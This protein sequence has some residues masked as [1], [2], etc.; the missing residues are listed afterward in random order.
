VTV[1]AQQRELLA[2]LL[3]VTG[4][5]V[6][7]DRPLEEERL[8]RSVEL[9]LDRFRPALGVREVGRDGR[10]ACLPDLQDFSFSTRM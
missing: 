1:H 10:L 8:V 7:V 9:G 5:D 4:V 3:G 6:D 2:Q